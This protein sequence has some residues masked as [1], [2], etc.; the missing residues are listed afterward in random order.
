MLQ[1]HRCGSRDANFWASDTAD[2]GANFLFRFDTADSGANFL[3]RFENADFT[4]AN[5]SRDADFLGVLIMLILGPTLVSPSFAMVFRRFSCPG[6][7]RGTFNCR[8]TQGSGL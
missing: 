6:H 5:F 3:F 8:I 1:I 7:L 4:G 2:S